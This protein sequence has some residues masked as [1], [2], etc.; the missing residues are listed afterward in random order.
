MNKKEKI[1]NA[2]TI[3]IVIILILTYIFN[4]NFGINKSNSAPK[5]VYLYLKPEDLKKGDYIVFDIDKK[6]KNLTM[7][8]NLKNIKV[9]FL[10]EIVAENGDNLEIRNNHLYVNGEDYGEYMDKIEKADLKIENGEYWVLSKEKNSLDSRYFGSVPKEKIEKK[11][12]LI[13]GFNR[14]KIN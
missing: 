2:S 3:F 10:K 8:R 9:R 11:A 14:K 4:L 5:G 12:K 1:F 13:Y 7:F 6:W